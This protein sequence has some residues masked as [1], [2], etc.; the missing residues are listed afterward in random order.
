MLRVLLTLC[1]L[2]TC[3]TGQDGRSIFQYLEDQGFSTLVE[4]IRGAGL[5][6]EFEDLD[7]IKTVFA[8]TNEAFKAVPDSVMVQLQTNV[9]LLKQVLLGH[10]VMDDTVLGVFIRD[11]LTKTSAAGTTLSFNKY[12]QIKTVNGAQISG[13]V[14]LANGVVQSINKVLLPIGDTISTIVAEGDAQFQDLFGFLILARLFGTLS[15]PGPYTVFAPTDAAFE[16]IDVSPLITNR[17]A[18]A[19]V[20]KD[21]VLSG[22]LWSAGL[23]DGMTLETLSGKQLTVHLASGQL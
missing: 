21:H 9:T 5:S 20:L 8:P 15:L 1:M 22:T 3:A 16:K 10:V 6:Q 17:T 13:D 4:L 23:T 18:L 11:G 19:D 7:A 2:C 12:N 14:L